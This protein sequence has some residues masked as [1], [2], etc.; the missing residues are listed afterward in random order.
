MGK[1]ETV[2]GELEL[3]GNVRYPTWAI[4]MSEHEAMKKRQCLSIDLVCAIRF[5]LLYMIASGR[6]SQEVFIGMYVIY[7]GF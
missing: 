5:C 7:N 6:Q 2:L 4:F 3:G 1:E